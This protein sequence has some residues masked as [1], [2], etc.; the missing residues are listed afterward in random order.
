LLWSYSVGGTLWYLAG[1][2]LL[3]D[4]TDVVAHKWVLGDNA[5]DQE[6]ILIAVLFH[7]AA[8]YALW[9]LAKFVVIRSFQSLLSAV[10]QIGAAWRG[11]L[12]R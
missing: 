12:H 5:G 4:V 3:I 11:E 2:A 6:F 8:G 1:V 10:S 7:F 9:R